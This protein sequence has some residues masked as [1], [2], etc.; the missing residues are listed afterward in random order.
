VMWPF[1]I[2]FGPI[3]KEIV[4][5]YPLKNEP[6]WAA[7][8]P[9]L[10]DKFSLSG[11]KLPSKKIAM[12]VGKIFSEINEVISKKKGGPNSKVLKTISDVRRIFIPTSKYQV[13]Q[14]SGISG[15]G[16]E[17]TMNYK[18]MFMVLP[19]VVIYE[20]DNKIIVKYFYKQGVKSLQYYWFGFCLIYISLTGIIVGFNIVPFLFFGTELTVTING[21][22][23]HNDFFAFFS[24]VAFMLFIPSLLIG[25]ALYFRNDLLNKSQLKVREFLDVL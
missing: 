23:R 18:N 14:Y 7:L 17:F 2:F 5:T 4:E 6:N 25:M 19:T 12:P 20:N 24:F 3:Q 13:E 16:C 9:L 11:N 22:V 21:E 1:S 15:P 8:S 10:A